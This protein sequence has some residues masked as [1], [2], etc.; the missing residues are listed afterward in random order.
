MNFPSC[1][2]PQNG[3]IYI[4]C[5]DKEEGSLTIHERDGTSLCSVLESVVAIGLRQIITPVL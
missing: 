1:T 2:Q 4:S 3:L 5:A